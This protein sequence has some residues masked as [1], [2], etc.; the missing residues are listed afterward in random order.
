MGSPLSVISDRL[1]LIFFFYGLSFSAMGL[2][3]FLQPKKESSFALA[4]SLWLLGCFGLAHGLNEFIDMWAIIHPPLGQGFPYAG[5]TILIASYLFLLEFGRRSVKALCGEVPAL[6]AKAPWLYARAL[7]PALLILA[8]SLSAFSGEFINSLTVLSRLLLGFPAALMAGLAFIGY[9]IHRKETLVRLKARKYF[10]LTG[11]AFLAYAALG[12]LVPTKGTIFPADLLNTEVFLAVVG[13][14]VQLFR[15]ACAAA[16]FAG[17]MGATRIF[18]EGALQA[19]Q[20]ELLDIIEFFPDATFVIDKDRKVIAWN[21]ALEKMTGVPKAEMLGKGGF[22]YS[23]PFYGEARPILID[24]I[25]AAHPEAEKFYQYVSKRTDG[26]IH[27]EVFVP[28]LYNGAGAHVWVT[29]SPLQDKEG[30]VYG[31]IESVRDVTDRKLAEEALQR[32]EAQYRALI[33]TTN[34]GFLIIDKEGRVLDA[35][36]EYVRLT[37]HRK[38]DEIR[39]RSVLD[40]TAAYERE[41]NARAIEDCARTGHIRNL[42]IDYT[43]KGGG[44]TPI[45]LNAT[46]VD[47]G[48]EPRILTLC[49]DITARRNSEKQLKESEGKFRTLTEKSLIGVYV[50]QDGLFRYINPK[51]SEIFGYAEDEL[52][53][54]KGPEDLVLPEDWPVVRENLRKRLD[55]EIADINYAFRGVKKDGTHLTVEVFGSRTEY[56]GRSAVLGTLLDIT[57]RKKAQDALLESEARYRT[58]VN[59]AQVGIVVHQLGLMKFVN[60]KMAQIVRVAGPEGVIGRNVLEFMHPDFR[61]F[62][63]QR[64]TEATAA[65][66]PLPPAEEKL[67]A[68]DGTVLDVE[69]N[70]VPITYEGVPCAMAIVQDI[71]PRKRAEA[72]LK[73]AH[74]QLLL[75][76]AGLE[77]RVEERTLQ[78]EELN[79][80]L[81]AFSY[82]AAHDMKAPLRRVNIFAEM[83]EKEAGPALKDEP[84]GMLRNIRKSVTEMTNLVEG[85]LTLSTTGR[86]PLKLEPVRLSAL[87][88]ESIA[89]IKAETANRAIEWTTAGL[90][91]VMCDRAMLK[92]VFMNLL[93]NAAK[94]SRGSEPARIDVLYHLKAGEHVISVR[95]NGVGFSMEYADRL[96]AVFQRLHKAEEFEGTGIGLSTVKRIISRHGGKVWAESAPGKGATFYFSLPAIKE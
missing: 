77:K 79:K 25:G 57:E 11:T 59:N 87:L 5:I 9:A 18:R 70:T 54:K 84:R 81:E 80:E 61:E 74:L 49:R 50:I 64:M 42:E 63:K 90:P 75:V 94:Y 34:T 88:D 51:M 3:L 66:T 14:P 91:E 12:G 1:D 17:I 39:G 47:I 16:I 92:Q 23:V 68:A 37:G 58:L 20:Q 60:N 62:V 45:E 15:A 85:L 19:A 31:A 52:A 32:S 56:M 27:A 8:I 95:D 82:S 10:M 41:K 6:N 93:G 83:L 89:E 65:G 38:L 86:K 78:L 96:F 4:D 69:I 22:A 28:S 44:I 48:G 35:N 21:R 67:V 7:T 13:L 73:T 2:L 29:A 72:E 26:A 53:G 30:H 71:T 33:E 46:V 24:L 40:W 43:A 55:G 36:Q 76:N